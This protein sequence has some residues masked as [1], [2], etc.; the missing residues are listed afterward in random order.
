MDLPLTWNFIIF[1]F[2]IVAQ[3]QNNKNKNATHQLH[4]DITKVVYWIKA[5]KVLSNSMFKKT[6]Y[7]YYIT[8]LQEILC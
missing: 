7:C 2:Y 4:K 8:W 3:M 5:V 6:G 1:G